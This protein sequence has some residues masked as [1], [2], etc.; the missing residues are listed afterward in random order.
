[1]P[2]QPFQPPDQ[3]NIADYFLDDRIREGQGGRTALRTDEATVSYAELQ[4]LANRF[5]SLLRHEGV[6]PEE[7]VRLARLAYHDQ[8]SI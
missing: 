5:G 4:A 2:P 3:L 7:R 8:G 1:M 6:R